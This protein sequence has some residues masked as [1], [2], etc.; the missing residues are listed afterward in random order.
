MQGVR[1][2]TQNGSIGEAIGRNTIN[3]A[4]KLGSGIKT[5]GKVGVA[6]GGAA[7]LGAGLLLHNNLNSGADSVKSGN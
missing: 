5:A 1:N 2:A 6:A 3:G 4:K 7:L